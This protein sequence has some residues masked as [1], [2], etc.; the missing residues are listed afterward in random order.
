MCADCDVGLC[1]V[2]CFEEFHTLLGLFPVVY[3]FSLQNKPAASL[4][5][6]KEVK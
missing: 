1:V 2:G 4:N 5:Q 3:F 6:L